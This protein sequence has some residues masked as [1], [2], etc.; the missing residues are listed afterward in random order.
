M[1][2]KRHEPMPRKRH[3]DGNGPPYGIGYQRI[4]L[5][6]LSHG[7]CDKPMHSGGS[8]ADRAEPCDALKFSLARLD[9]RSLK[10]NHFAHLTTAYGHQ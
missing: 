9:L 3:S 5:D 1:I 8:Q 6:Q 7:N 4:Q 2:L 10:M